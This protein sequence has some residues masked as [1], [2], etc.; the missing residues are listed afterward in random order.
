[1]KRSLVLV[2]GLGLLMSAS[3]RADCTTHIDPEP[4]AEGHIVRTRVATC[5][6]TQ[7]EIDQHVAEQMALCA[8]ADAEAASECAALVAAAQQ[9]TR[10]HLIRLQLQQGTSIEDIAAAT[11]AS[12]EDIEAI[13]AAMTP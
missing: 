7:A 12:I 1:M 2:F 4:D 8:A 5:D 11:G 13:Q 9:G 3:A 10:D 6:T